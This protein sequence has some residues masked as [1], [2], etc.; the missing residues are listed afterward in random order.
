MQPGIRLALK[1]TESVGLGLGPAITALNIF[2]FSLT[3][4]GNIFYKSGTTWGIFI[5]VLLISLAVVA[6]KW[7]R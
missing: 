2:G 5:G 4:G 7:Q 6:R 3:R 1:I